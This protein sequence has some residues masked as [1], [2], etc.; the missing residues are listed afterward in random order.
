MY[1]Q[2]STH[3]PL[4][5]LQRLSSLP[6][7]GKATFWY[8]AI[9][10]LPYPSFVFNNR[11]AMGLIRAHTLSS[12]LTPFYRNSTNSFSFFFGNNQ[13]NVTIP[14]LRNSQSGSIF[15]ENVL[16]AQMR[17]YHGPPLPK[18]TC[19]AILVKLNFLLLGLFLSAFFRKFLWFLQYHY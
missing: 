4:V 2:V 10:S 1:Q 12:T 6:L 11:E 13:I 5:K 8:T 18:E 7:S 19:T 9:F 14:N 15:L 16:E 17:I 3:I